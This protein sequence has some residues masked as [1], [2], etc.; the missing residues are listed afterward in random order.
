MSIVLATLWW[1]AAVILTVAAIAALLSAIRFFRRG[2]VATFIDAIY[3][4]RERAK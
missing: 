2:G 3:F 4:C 1:S